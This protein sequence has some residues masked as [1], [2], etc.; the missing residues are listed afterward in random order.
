MKNFFF[1]FIFIYAG[2][3]LSA[4]DTIAKAVP[5]DSGVVFTYVEVM[6]SFPGGED[7]LKEYFEKNLKHPPAET[8]C[9]GVIYVKCVVERDGTLTSIAVKKCIPACPLLETEAIRVISLMP[10]WEP[11]RMSGKNVRVEKVITVRF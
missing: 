10:A 2:T 8:E 6:P 3:I 9:A 7:A 5:K 1:L 4:Q 11:G